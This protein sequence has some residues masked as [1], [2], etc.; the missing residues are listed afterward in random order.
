[1]S[2]WKIAI[3]GAG[4]MATEHA[5]AFAVLPDVEIVGVCGRNP[6]RAQA[7]AEA[8]GVQ[9][10]ETIDSLFE[11]TRADAVVVT[12]NE[13]SMGDVCRQAFKHPWAALLEKPV[14]LDLAE[15]S[16]ILSESRD[17]KGPA[18]VALN[19][20]S[21]GST[22]ASLQELAQEQGPR[23]V[24]VLDQQDMNAARSIRQPEPVV[25]N[26]MYAN[27]IHLVDYF[28]IF[29]RGSLVG[30]DVTLPWDAAKP[31]AVCATLRY[32]SGDAGVYQAVW[33]GPGPWA[34]SVTNASVRLEMR[35][36]ESLTVQRRGE[37]RA[38]PV[39]LGSA[40]TDF[41]PG[42]RVQAQELIRALEGQTPNLAT[43][44]DATKS[45]AVVAKIYG[46]A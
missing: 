15:A 2:K 38:V 32:D 14:G 11:A 41:K 13:L 29:C 20:R 8:Y 12:V 7:L 16:Q 5:K 34:V 27:S 9:A 43:L 22:L 46:L 40:D 3:V 37:R 31:G 35:P 36:L 33:D 10:Y 18:W 21:H 1:M 44:D 19:R 42:L 17:A 28:A 23:L 24:S 26:W 4:Y 30:V 25:L 45:M 6:A 39:E